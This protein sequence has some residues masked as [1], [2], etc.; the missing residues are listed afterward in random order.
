M[1][2]LVTLAHYLTV[3][4]LAQDDMGGLVD[5]FVAREAVASVALSRPEWPPLDEERTWD[6]WVR[7]SAEGGASDG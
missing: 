2:D 1:G 7:W 4:T 3:T 6:E 5:F